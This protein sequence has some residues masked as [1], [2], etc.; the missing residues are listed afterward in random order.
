MRVAKD[1]MTANPF[2]LSSKIGVQEAIKEMMAH[3]ISTLPVLGENNLLM[4]Q[5]SEVVLLKAFILSSTKENANKT[6]GDYS[7]LF[8]KPT[9][10]KESDPLDVVVK[11]ILSSPFHRVLVVNANKQLK[12]IISPKDLLRFLMG[13][14]HESS[15]LSEELLI[16]K[17]R[18]AILKDQLKATKLEL[19]SIGEIV[20]KSPF[21][22]HSCDANF[23][24]IVANEKLH[25]E[26]GYQSKELIGRPIFEIYHPQEKQR[27]EETIKALIAS[28][29]NIKVYGTFLRKNKQPLKVEIIS[30]AIRNS[31]GEFVSTSSMSRILDS[32]SLL[33]VL[34]GIYTPE[35]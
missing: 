2:S 1:L 14:T 33:R 20:E 11:S 4:G 9:L 22:F 29:Q 34:H 27:V 10:V 6:L 16:M 15:T 13:E 8:S 25:S 30:S 19:T 21:M 35:E 28:D 7:D 31:K 32:D 3:K 23:N 18:V 5:I 26:L 24:I 12:G 17:D